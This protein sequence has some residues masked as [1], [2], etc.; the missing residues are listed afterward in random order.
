MIYESP[1]INFCGY[2][3]YVHLSEQVEPL[4]TLEEF[5]DHEILSRYRPEGMVSQL[6]I[7]RIHACRFIWNVDGRHNACLSHPR[8]AWSSS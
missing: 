3:A 6:L 4:M 2:S 8:A 7:S 1:Q 5:P